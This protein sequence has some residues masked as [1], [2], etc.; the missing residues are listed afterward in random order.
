MRAKDAM[1]QDIRP[2]KIGLLNL[3][4]QKEKTELQLA[5]LIGSTPLQIQLTLITTGSYTPS[6]VSKQHMLDFYR[7]WE[8]V[9]DQK[10]DG[11]I[12]TGAPV[13]LLPFEEVLYWPELCR[14]FEWTQSN[15]H[16]SLNICWGAQA[17]LYYFHNVPKHK[18]KK[19]KFGLFHH[20][21]VRPNSILLRGFDDGFTIP[22]SRHTETKREDLPKI[23][24]LNVLADSP[25]SGLCLLR[26]H[27]KRQVYMFNHLEYDAHTLADEYNRDAHEGLDTAL[28]EH[29]FIN[30][31]P[32]QIP[33]NTWRSHAHLMINNW[34]NEIYQG[35][36]YDRKLI[37]QN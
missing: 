2:L 6:N 29:Y 32:K 22:V 20:H 23:E 19:K 33:T 18:L 35:T 15:V 5:R 36:P 8:D 4:P 31:D 28:P 14:I 34:I 27:T 24:G 13:E 16:S 17:A 10:F 21:V 7:P 11:L 37:G 3:M 30:D 9:K 26:D 1:R 12:I 25:Q